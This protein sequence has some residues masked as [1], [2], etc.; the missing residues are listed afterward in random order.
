MPK[1]IVLPGSVLLLLI[2][3]LTQAASA[4]MKPVATVPL[5]CESFSQV[6]SP[7]GDQVALWCK[8]H[9]VRLMNLSSGTTVRSF[10]PDPR[11]SEVKYSRDGHWFAVGFG[12]GTVEAVPTSGT[13]EGKRWKSDTRGI[14]ALEFLPDSSEIVVAPLDR[15]GQIWDLRGAPKQLAT[16]HS[17]FAGLLACSFSSDGKLLVTAD[18]DTAI[19]FYDTSTWKMLH[20]Y[21][22]VTL[23]TF[24]V[25]F[26]IDGKRVLIGGPDD[27]ITVL[28]PA[29]GA[30]LQ[31]LPKDPDV[32]GQISPFGSDGQAAVSY[33]D[34]DGRRPEHHSIWNVNTA[35]S[36]PLTL[37]HSL[38]GSAIVKG[39]LWLS[40][41]SGKVLDIWVYE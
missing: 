8:D 14:G 21:R 10:G 31:K 34:V 15:P 24:A 36:V 41:T 26:T 1:R 27:R 35:K 40:S 28:D 20:E 13:A 2:V 33:F 38:T 12:E 32:I 9:T 25:A 18:G 17:D 30:E 7:T 39:K 3:S 16:L 5:P 4:G 6:I 23:E 19:R 29:T 11:V 22:G 37:D